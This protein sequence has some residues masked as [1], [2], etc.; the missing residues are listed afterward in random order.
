MLQCFFGWFGVYLWLM[1]IRKAGKSRKAKK[2][3]GSTEEKQR[4]KEAERQHSGEAEKQRSKEAKKQKSGEAEKQRTI[5]AETQRKAERQKSR[6][7]EK[8][9]KAE[10]QRSR[11][12]EIVLKKS[13]KKGPK[14]KPFLEIWSTHKV[15]FDLCGSLS[16]V[17]E[18]SQCESRFYN[19]HP[20]SSTIHFP[21]HCHRINTPHADK[22]NTLHV[23]QSAAVI[24]W[25]LP[26][27][28]FKKKN[29]QQMFNETW[30]LV[31]GKS[32][33]TS[34]G[35]LPIAHETCHALPM[36][37]SLPSQSL[38]AFQR[39]V[40]WCRP[41]S[42]SMATAQLEIPKIGGKHGTATLMFCYS[43]SHGLLPWSACEQ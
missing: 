17:W 29:N 11:E 33:P 25:P 37:L 40:H 32:L 19:I 20:L 26:V 4:S 38:K 9:K 5:K 14:K 31:E 42:G 13:G 15:S 3:R 43:C 12:T 7:A 36:W 22:Q 2:Q 1:K 21:W 30:A 39:V 6:K 35:P 34:T 41:S 16:L 27:V 28:L 18:P 23:L 8:Q 10:K 24:V